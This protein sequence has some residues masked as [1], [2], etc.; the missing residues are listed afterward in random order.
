[1][2]THKIEQQKAKQE[3][4]KSRCMSLIKA[5]KRVEA[6]RLYRHETGADLREAM[7]EL[8]LKHW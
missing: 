7:R 1:M 8:G 4:L 5:G 6:I 3:E 2:N